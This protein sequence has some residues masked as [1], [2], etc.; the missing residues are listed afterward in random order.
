MFSKILQEQGGRKQGRLR[1]WIVSVPFDSRTGK[2]YMTVKSEYGKGSCFSVSYKL[3]D[4]E[5][6]SV[7]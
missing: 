4:L 6:K 3:S 1:N 2:G 5:T 7:I